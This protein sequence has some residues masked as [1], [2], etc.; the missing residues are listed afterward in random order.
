M[1]AFDDL[2]PAKGFDDIPS[3]VS[4]KENSLLQYHRDNLNNGTQLLQNGQT[5]TV[6]IT[7]ITGADGRIYNVPGY[8]DGRRYDVENSQQDQ[9]DLRQKIDSIGWDNFPSYQSEWDG[10]REDH[11]ANVAARRIHHIIDKDMIQYQNRGDWTRKAV[12]KN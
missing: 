11:P 5:T 7:G 4:S 3:D 6:N 8:W 12:L 9:I 2:I 1:G 10:A